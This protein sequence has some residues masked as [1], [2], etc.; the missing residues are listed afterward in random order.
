MTIWIQLFQNLYH[1]STNSHA[2]CM[3]L[4][5]FALLSL[6]QN[7]SQMSRKLT[8]SLLYSS[9]TLSKTQSLFSCA[10]PQWALG[11]K[12][13][14]QMNNNMWQVWYQSI[15]C[16]LVT[17]NL[18]PFCYKRKAKK[19]PWNTSNTWSKFAQIEGIFLKIN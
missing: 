16:N 17:C 8:V 5:Y 15:H 9:I 7:S 1:R 14:L 19:M 10:Q 2:F 4:K 13:H 3:I 18:Q 6:T 12:L 11:E